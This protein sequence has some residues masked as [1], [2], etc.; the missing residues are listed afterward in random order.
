MSSHGF[1]QVSS[2]VFHIEQMFA[3]AVTQ[4]ATRFSN[5]EFA[6]ESTSSSLHSIHRNFHLRSMI[7]I[8]QTFFIKTTDATTFGRIGSRLT[9]DST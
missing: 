8:R 2:F 6:A 3:K 1:R 7:T 9:D 4:C 5:V